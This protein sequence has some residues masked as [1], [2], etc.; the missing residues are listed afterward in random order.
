MTLTFDIHIGSCTHLVNCIYQLWYHRYNKIGHGQPRVI[1]W[2]NLE[3][4]K[5]LMLHTKFQDHWLFGSEEKI[6]LGFYHTHAYGHGGHLGHVIWTIWTNFR[7]PS[8]GG[9][10]VYLAPL[11][12]LPP[13]GASCPG[14]SYPP[15]WLSSPPGGKLSRPVY[16]AP[17]PYRG[18][19]LI[20]CFQ[21]ICNILWY[22]HVFLKL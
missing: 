14:L 11:D 7:S 15:P 10:T 6:F 4:L 9:V 22:L 5:H 1:I 2:T 12:S 18:N 16:L 3:V 21:F 20:W 19:N 8:H 13:G 17:H